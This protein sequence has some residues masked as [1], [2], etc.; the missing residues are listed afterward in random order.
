MDCP[1]CGKA[2][3]MEEKAWDGKHLYRYQPF[4]R[5]EFDK[6]KKIT[7]HVE[8][9]DVFSKRELFFPSP[10][11]FNDPFDCKGLT[12]Q[13]DTHSS[14][15]LT[16]KLDNDKKSL[17]ENISKCGVLCLSE[18]DSDLL[19]WAHYADSH[20]GYCLKFNH[21]EIKKRQAA[22]KAFLF[23]KVSYK[24]EMPSSDAFSLLDP[25]IV[26]FLKLFLC[27][28]SSHWCY[29]NEWRI[30]VDIERFS[31]KLYFDE[32]MLSG[33]IFGCEMN[34]DNIKVI[35]GHLKEWTAKPALYK[36]VKNKNQY[37]LDIV[38]EGY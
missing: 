6:E 9:L 35:K 10:A 23:K 2:S 19:M 8:N 34:D 21:A 1:H 36:A 16:G 33:V 24:K 3:D 20:K 25:D 7:K 13:A 11:N 29:E 31:Q 37:A 38:P 14:S 5:R 18:K 22:L 30:V 17:C 4:Y 26:E 12:K 28:K 27:T 32:T 15:D